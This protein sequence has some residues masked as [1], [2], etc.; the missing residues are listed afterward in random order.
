MREKLSV[1]TK[2]N[3]TS[4][5]LTLTADSK[6]C[7]TLLSAHIGIRYGLCPR[8][9]LNSPLEESNRSSKGPQCQQSHRQL[10]VFDCIF[11]KMQVPVGM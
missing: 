6:V 4:F 7:S 3:V 5:I 8:I 9:D 10:S 11:V 2:T 1:D